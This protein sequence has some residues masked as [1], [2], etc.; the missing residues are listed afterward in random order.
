MNIC[1]LARHFDLKLNSG[2]G[3]VATQIKQGVEARGHQVIT[4]QDQGTTPWNYLNYCYGLPFG[5]SNIRK[6][7]P[8]KA[9]V[10]HAI[11]P[12]ESVFLPANKSVCTF[13]DLIQEIAP[14]RAGSGLN[15]NAVTYQGGIMAYQIADR[16]AAR[17]KYVVATSEYLKDQLVKVLNINPDRITVIRLGIN[18]DLQPY[19]KIKIINGRAF[20]DN[21]VRI[22][23]LGQLDKRKRVDLL[24]KAFMQADPDAEL[25]IAGTGPDEEALKTLSG[26][27]GNIR[28]LGFVPDDKLSEWFGS[29]DVLV[30]PSAIEGYGLT[31]VEAFACKKP[32]ITLTDSIMP[33]EIQRRTYVVQPSNL[34]AIFKDRIPYVKGWVD[35]ES[36]YVWAKTE[37]DWNNTITK[38]LD[39]YENILHS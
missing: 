15:R 7:T 22:G 10:Y 24:I 4:V 6:L 35:L 39:L 29:I 2:L 38:Y 19:P 27:Y 1:M 28:F 3:R 30:H 25:S 26:T 20:Q 18:P 36:N 16:R 21:T 23:Y 5:K 31:I 14:E 11:T 9:D 37:H 8:R 32:V 33:L 12:M 17:C 34:P 13:H